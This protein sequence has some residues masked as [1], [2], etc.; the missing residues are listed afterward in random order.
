MK[1]KLIDVESSNISALGF[2]KNYTLVVR[3]KKGFVYTYTGVTEQLFQD[4]LHSHSVGKFFHE[5]IL[6]SYPYQKHPTA[7]IVGDSVELPELTVV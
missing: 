3:F 5:N 6:G 4:L 1:V 2:V 7:L